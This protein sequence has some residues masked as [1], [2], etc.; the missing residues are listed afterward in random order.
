[1]PG[2]G[3]SLEGHFDREKD[4]AWHA[5]PNIHRANRSWRERGFGLVRTVALLQGRSQQPAS[6]HS[7]PP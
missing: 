3:R 4:E 7:L 2:S 1:M 5:R 6:V